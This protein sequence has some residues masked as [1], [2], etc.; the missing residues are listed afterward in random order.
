MLLLQ[1]RHYRGGLNHH[2]FIRRGPTCACGRVTM[3]KI[4]SGTWDPVSFRPCCCCNKGR[5]R[6]SG[7]A[8]PG[9]R[10]SDL[11][12]VRLARKLDGWI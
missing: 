11:G 3:Q 4:A 2:P 9:G 6:G 1:Y 7:L 10:G 5:E 8:G 12:L